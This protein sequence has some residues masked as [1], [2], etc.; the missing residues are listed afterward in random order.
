MSAYNMEKTM[1]KR[2]S[3]ITKQCALS[4][5]DWDVF[6]IIIRKCNKKDV[7]KGWYGK[8]GKIQPSV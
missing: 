2:E 8:T 6:Q 5:K 1:D 4:T 3:A 7:G